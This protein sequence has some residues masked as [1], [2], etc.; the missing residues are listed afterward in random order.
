[1]GE[2]L[3]EDRSQPF[4]DSG[5]SIRA[6]NM[7]EEQMGGGFAHQSRQGT[8]PGKSIEAA[9]GRI[10]R[11]VCDQPDFE[12]ERWGEQAKIADTMLREAGLELDYRQVGDEP[13]AD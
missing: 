2:K 8:A 10:V 4:A 3:I 7:V 5:R 6:V 9:E 1:M 12:H 11:V 13:P